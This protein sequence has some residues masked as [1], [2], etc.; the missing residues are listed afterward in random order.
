MQKCLDSWHVVYTMAIV[1]WISRHFVY[2]RAYLECCSLGM[3]F[4]NFKR[5]MEILHVL[6]YLMILW[7]VARRYGAVQLFG[8][9]YKT[10]LAAIFLILIGQWLNVSVYSSIGE[11]GVYYQRELVG[12]QNKAPPHN[13]F[14]FTIMPH[15]M[16]V[17]CIITA[18][19]LGLLWG[20]N[21]H[22]KVLYPIWFCVGIVIICYLFSIYIE[23]KPSPCFTT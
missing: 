20:I 16:Y 17:G 2:S 5:V 4:E 1:L 3:S 6:N 7:L 23:S 19:G 12:I 18:L 10:R 8:G 11:D 21:A 9:T 13:V 15:P 14:L 22:G